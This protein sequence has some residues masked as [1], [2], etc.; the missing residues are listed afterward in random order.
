MLTP[1][2]YSSLTCDY[3]GRKTAIVLTSS[4]II[5]GL[6]LSAASNGHTISGMF[7]MLTISRGITGFGTGGEYPASSTSASEAA[8][9]YTLK[10]R[11]TIFIL[12]T[13]LPLSFG[14]P[15]ASSIF[16]IVLQITTTKHLSTLWRTTF[17]IGVIFP[18]TIFYWRVRMVNSKLY[19]R[20]AIKRKVPYLLIARYYWRTLIGT[21][22]AWFLYDFVTIPNSVFSTNI[23]SAVVPAGNIQK[24]AEW[25]L[26]LGTIALPGVF[27]GALLVDVLGRKNVMMIGFG[28]FL[29]FGLIVGCAFDKISK[30]LPLFIVLYGV[31]LSFGNLGPGDMI[32]LISSESYATAVRGSCYGLSAA[33]GKAG[34]AVGTEVFQP[35]EIHLGTRWTFIIAAICGAVGILVTWIF[36]PNL[37][38]DDLALED[39]KFRAYLVRNGWHGKMGE[40]DLKDE[41]DAGI[42]DID[43]SHIK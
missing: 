39:E 13:N 18:V 4:M 25:Q 16:L 10:R 6:I 34:A 33:M 7:W 15:L 24:T 30:I 1:N 21:T 31:M 3:I 22:G 2:F 43:I 14:V 20:G 19:R 38:G 28:G 42:P 41:A 5:L 27:V 29:V 35:I 12:V 32:G 17:A 11:G 37:T 40:E 26:L 23:I 36:V 8:N 9:A